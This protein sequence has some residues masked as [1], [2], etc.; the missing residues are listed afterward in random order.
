MLG[1]C[2]YVL[3]LRF[4]VLRFAVFL[5]AVF[6]FAVFLFAVFLFALFRFALFRFALFKF[7]LFC[8][9]IFN[10][11]FCIQIIGYLFIQI[12]WRQMGL[13]CDFFTIRRMV[14]IFINFLLRLGFVVFYYLLIGLSKIIA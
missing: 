11:S 2:W 6:L 8:F 10:D 13:S 9:F 3:L 1:V 12:F 14:M 4:A 7:A 5:F